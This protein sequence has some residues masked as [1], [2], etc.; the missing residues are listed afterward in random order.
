MEKII[1]GKYPYKDIEKI[2]KKRKLKQEER[3]LARKQQSDSSKRRMHFIHD[4]K[5]I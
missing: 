4:N 1:R 2:A 3:K 5:E